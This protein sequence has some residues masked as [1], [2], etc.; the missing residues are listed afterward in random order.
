MHLPDAT[1]EWYVQNYLDRYY[2]VRFIMKMNGVEFPDIP[3]KEA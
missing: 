1:Y 3:T 2:P